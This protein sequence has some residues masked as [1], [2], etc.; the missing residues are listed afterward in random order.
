MQC[1]GR[2]GDG[3]NTLKTMLRRMHTEPQQLC[4]EGCAA[5]AVPR[6]LCHEGLGELP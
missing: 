3:A 6:M 2:K 5:K 1:D 4:R